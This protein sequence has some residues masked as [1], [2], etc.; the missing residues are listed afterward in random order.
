MNSVF[1]VLIKLHEF[2]WHSTFGW[3]AESSC[4]GDFPRWFA[5]PIST[6]QES[7]IQFSG[8]PFI[9]FRTLG[10]VAVVLT[11]NR[12]PLLKTG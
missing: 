4:A 10:I 11:A 6:L 2:Y 5:V 7:V 1:D 9:I 8:D 12:L 3:Q